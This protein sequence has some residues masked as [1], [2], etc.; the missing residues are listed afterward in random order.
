MT[1][2]ERNL[3]LLR[4]LD[5]SLAQRILESLVDGRKP[6]DLPSSSGM[7][8]DTFSVDLKGT[9][10]LLEKKSE[11]LGQFVVHSS[12]IPSR[13]KH[14]Y[15]IGHEH[16]AD[17]DCHVKLL[18][19]DLRE[20]LDLSR[21]SYQQGTEAN[22]GQCT[23]LILL[24]VPDLSSVITL[25]NRSKPLVIWCLYKNVTEWDQ[26]ITSPLLISFTNTV[27]QLR[28]QFQS[29]P[30]KDFKLTLNRSIRDD[31]L[32]CVGNMLIVY[33]RN[34][35]VCLD[36]V[37]Y[38]KNQ[39]LPL[40][41]PVTGGPCVD[42]LMMLKHTLANM[43]NDSAGFLRKINN[44]N[45]D[46]FIVIGSG[47]SLDDSIEAIKLLQ[48]SCLIVSAGSSMGTLLKHDI[49]PDFHVHVERGGDG[50]ATDLYKKMLAENNRKTF[51]GIVGVAPTSIEPTLLS[52]Y[53]HS[54]LYARQGQSPISVWP[55]LKDS[56]LLHEGPQCVSAAFA[57]VLHLQPREVYLF[58]CDLGSSSP[59]KLR[60]SQAVGDG[61]RI[62]SSVVP[63][64]LSPVAYTNKEITQQITFMEAS[65]ASCSA[66][67][68]I[69]NSSN[70]I[71]IPFAKPLS[72]SSC[73]ARG[74]KKRLSAKELL[75][76]ISSGIT[77]DQRK[78]ILAGN[79][80]EWLKQWIELSIS[81]RELPL[82]IVQIRASKLLTPT[83]ELEGQL[84]YRL[85][86]GTI[87][88]GFWLTAKAV[89]RL[90]ATQESQK[91]CWKDFT[92]MLMTLELELDN[93]TMLLR[94]RFQTA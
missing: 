3:D 2:T 82:S 50:H 68:V 56:I 78:P 74:L 17:P 11:F 71:R 9:T 1:L 66:K 85:F 15:W 75:P 7:V 94:D 45:T 58:G 30:V 25:L 32:G 29:Q 55:W 92:M 70:G 80:Q 53:N 81:A 76:S 33:D 39:F 42:E 84:S 21:T 93:I 57:F 69:F 40:L 62:F 6:A 26:W 37:D 63:G 41:R 90:G 54:V 88:D 22:Q 38:I 87:R 72:L 60:S 27:K 18:L 79:T 67:P 5:A 44:S 28:S 61:S 24:G 14:R 91:S 13:D 31:L 51:Q 64:N 86:R 59:A 10:E 16:H 36:A 65:L 47:P 89:Q 48:G 43:K 46:Q 73:K 49:E 8:V 12:K 77:V 20:N 35:P 34:D 4:N 83:Q 19:E 52:L 23:V